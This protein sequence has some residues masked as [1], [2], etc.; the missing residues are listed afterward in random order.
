MFD[1]QMRYLQLSERWCAD[2]SLDC[3][4]VLGRSHYEI[5]PD[6]P[7]YW[8]DLHRRG[9]GGEALRSE[10]DRWVRKDGT[11][12][13]IR[14][15]IR[16]WMKSDGVVGGIL[17][18]AEDI[19]HRKLLEQTVSEMNQKLIISQEKERTR[20]A[21]ELHDDI[22]QRIAVIAAELEMLRERPGLQVEVSNG[23]AELREQASELAIDVQSLSHSLHSPKLEYL[24][25]AVAMKSFC[26][27]FGEH[28]KIEVDFQSQDL[29][30][31]V[32][33][34]ISLSLFRVL[35]EAL[36]NS[37]KHSGVKQIEVRLWGTSE[38]VALTVRDSG[39][40]FEV[41]AAKESVGLGLIN[42]EERVKLVNGELSIESHPNRGTKIH[43]Q[44]R[45]ASG[46]KSS[47]MAG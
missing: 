5:F 28:H 15:E 4:K 20:I 1:S 25:L 44:V 12:K 41:E 7:Q 2:Y 35:Q 17:I 21:R 8:R 37:A 26:R 40:G 3:E 32:P 42:M 31:L 13:W 14:W 34:D 45:L 43:A 38:H 33:P 47:R 24:G 11:V 10:E 46:D 39:A 19:T 16:P 18:F 6:V 36:Q 30:E 9:L 29:P 23:L 22:G 27:E